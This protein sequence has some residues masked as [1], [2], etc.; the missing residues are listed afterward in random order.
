ML[1]AGRMQSRYGAV[2]SI[3]IGG[4][5]KD[6]VA[7]MVTWDTKVTTLV[8][9]CGGIGELTSIWLTRNGALTAFVNRTESVY[10]AVFPNFQQRVNPNSLPWPTT[11]TSSIGNDFVC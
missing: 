2:E 7:P 1:S 3:A 5:L 4:A 9:L 6:K 8:G 11:V 10:A